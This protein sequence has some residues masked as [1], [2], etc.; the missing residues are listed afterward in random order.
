MSASRQPRPGMRRKPQWFPPTLPRGGHLRERSCGCAE[1]RR[2]PLLCSMEPITLF[3]Q[4]RK[5][6]SGMGRE[7]RQPREAPPAPSGLAGGVAR[8]RE[9]RETWL[10]PSPSSL[11]TAISNRRA[12]PRAGRWA[13]AEGG[14]GAARPQPLCPPRGRESGLTAH[15]LPEVAWRSF[16]RSRPLRVLCPGSG[17]LGSLPHP[18]PGLSPSRASQHWAHPPPPSDFGG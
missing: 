18:F 12:R 10:L 1:A 7:R 11:S 9:R 2:G 16:R 8:D 3:L 5:R 14:A 6:P 4:P 15:A 17:D 13:R